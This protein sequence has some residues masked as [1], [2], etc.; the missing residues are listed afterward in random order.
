MT[1]LVLRLMAV[2]AVASSPFVGLWG[3]ERTFAPVAE[4]ELTVVRTDT[5]WTASLA[6]F[7]VTATVEGRAIRFA[8]PEGRGEFRGWMSNRLP[9]VTRARWTI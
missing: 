2:A 7:D 8:L 4:G 9:L 5:E 3:S 6:G 1:P